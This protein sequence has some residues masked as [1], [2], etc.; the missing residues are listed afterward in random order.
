MPRFP[1]FTIDRLSFWLG[2]LA[3]TLFWWIFNRAKPWLVRAVRII[4]ENRELSKQK[5]LTGLDSHLRKLA[6][7][8]GQKMHLAANLFSLDEI[9][10]QPKLIAPPL[11][12]EPETTPPSEALIN[13]AVPYLP[14]WP[15]FS[16]NYGVSTLSPAEALLGGVNIVITG[17]PGSG[18]TVCLANLAIQIARK[19]ISINPLSQSVPIIFHILD[20]DYAQFPKEFPLDPIYKLLVSQVSLIDQPKLPGF[21][22]IIFNNGNAFLLID[23]LDELPKEDL[24]QAILFIKSI[25]STYPLV[26][27]ITT[28]ASEYVDGLTS[29]G[30]QPLAL[31]AWSQQEC[32]RFIHQWD[33]QWKACLQPLTEALLEDQQIVEPLLLQNWLISDAY[34]LSPLEWTL[35]IWSTYTGDLKGPSCVDALDSYF[36]RMTEG[37][38]PLS[39]MGEL[40]Y[41]MLQDSK[42]GMSFSEMEKLLSSWQHEV[43]LPNETDTVGTEAKSENHTG[44]SAQ[45]KKT[46]GER[47]LLFLLENGLLIERSKEFLTFPNPCL[48]GYLASLS[49]ASKD[50]ELIPELPGWSIEISTL[51]YLAG[52]SDGQWLEPLIN[53]DDAPLYRNYLMLGRWLKDV[54]E[55]AP[56][57]TGLFR[58]L[59]S[60][61][62][63]ESLPIGLIARLLSVFIVSNDPSVPILTRQLL[64]SKS[65]NIR[66]LAA[67]ACGAIHDLKAVNELKMML[68]D[69]N[70][71]VRQSACLALSTIDSPVAFQS[72]VDSLFQGDES[73]RRIAA[74]SLANIGSEGYEVLKN[75]ITLNDLLVRRA[76]VFGLALIRE[77][78]SITLLEKITIE[79]G[80]WVVRNAAAQAHE[81]MLKIKPGTPQPLPAP[82]DSPWLITYASRQGLGIRAQD[83]GIEILLTA[84]KSGSYDEQA[85]SLDYLRLIPDEGVIHCL[86]DIIYNENNPLREQ[87]YDAL[88]FLAC[89]GAEIP[90]P[91]KFGL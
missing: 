60:M 44:N 14:D 34:S 11:R 75:G 8:Q 19:D 37:S 22:D 81:A 24:G 90:R 18:K 21:L 56:W 17:Q 59:V 80:Q 31:A 55:S 89:S 76:I 28:G 49:A 54:P 39:L 78:W 68:G 10:I 62:Q 23:G 16:A 52:N 26:H 48:T 64:T 73:L 4:R 82:S 61:I 86:Y 87:A 57:R 63:N 40:A 83:S 79:D 6:F 47:T 36:V 45:T 5:A 69:P 38:I 46:S 3:A 2:F 65:A 7:N 91:S 25:T 15:E 50:L 30:F 9:I 41:Q 88:C 58:S 35:K 51:H 85:A 32:I 67:L 77:P 70:S 13:S 72:V 66:G 33:K 20:I 29:I 12:I 84:L 53:L 71:E 42:P 74:E 27:I 43:H 1:F